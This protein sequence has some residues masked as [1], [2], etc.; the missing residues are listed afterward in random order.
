MLSARRWTAAA[1]AIVKIFSGLA[2]LF[3]GTDAQWFTLFIFILANFMLNCQ[4]I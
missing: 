1:V 3:K 4:D 2:T